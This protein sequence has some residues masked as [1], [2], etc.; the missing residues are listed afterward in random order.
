MPSFNEER[1]YNLTIKDDGTVT[2]TWNFKLTEEKVAELKTLLNRNVATKKGWSVNVDNSETIA[3]A[4]YPPPNY[5][6][7]LC[8]S[9]ENSEIKRIIQ[10]AEQIA[11]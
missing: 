3:S 6:Q 1:K 10:V 5:I 4:C 2:I 11:K 9:G 8:G 7:L